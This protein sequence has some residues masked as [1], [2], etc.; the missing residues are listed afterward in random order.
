MAHDFKVGDAV[1]LKATSSP[2]MTVVKVKKNA[3]GV[4]TAS[5]TWFV[6]TEAQSASYPADALRVVIPVES[7]VK[8]AKDVD[9]DLR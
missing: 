3:D 4:L 5:C 8:V 2:R 6:G 1:H 9:F 7:G